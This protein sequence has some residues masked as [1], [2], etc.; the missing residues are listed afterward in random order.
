MLPALSARVVAALV[1]VGGAVLASPLDRSLAAQATP[2]IETLVPLDSARRITI[3]TPTLVTRLGL[4][5]PAWPVVGP[6]REAR[7]YRVDGSAHVLVVQRV[8]STV[9]RF[10]LDVD[11]VSTLQRAIG[12]GLLAQ[13]RGGDRLVGAG[14]GVVV[15]QPAGNTFVR[16]QTFLGLVAYGPATAAILSKSSGAAAAGGYFLAAGTSFFVAANTVKGRVVTR[17]QA[18]RAAHGGTRGAL[19]GLGIAAI[20]N[21]DGGPGWGAPI[22]AGAIGGTIVG[23][24]QARGLSD[25]EAA[26]A[27][28]FADLGALTALGIGGSSG[29][30]EGKKT[31]VQFDAAN[32]QYGGY[33]RTDNSLRGPGKAIVGAAIGAQ[34]I[35]YALGPRYARRAAYNVT[36]GDV[37]V[38]FAGALLG[39]TSASSLIPERG[40]NTARF[41]V[42]AAGLVAGAFL[43]DRG[44]VRKA[45]RTSADG[46]LVQLG[47]LAGALMGG[48]IA[49]I[50][51]TESQGT[52][53]FASAGGILGL[54]AADGI[55]KPARDAGPL[56]GIMQSSARALDGRVF[57]SL[58]PVTSVRVTF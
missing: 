1:A 24:N 43:A 9:A 56:R 7:L 53:A 50:T 10:A 6:F 42:A 57:L 12:A 25:G 29:V 20:A 5:A 28:F 41:G 48:G 21:A 8:D 33:T 32:P 3:V 37:S 36:A 58:G 2:V 23:F 45:D 17:A 15:S 49:A 22:L 18:A 39:G 44:L 16:N 38:A 27:G 26:S 31:V 52:L 46:T 30:F 55:I 19:T 4:A 35:G 51:K 40:D 11:A 47:A 54:L 14:S 13:G 34:V